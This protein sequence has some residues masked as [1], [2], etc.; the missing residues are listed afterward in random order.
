MFKTAFFGGFFV[1]SGVTAG[2][3][4]STKNVFIFSGAAGAAVDINTVA[5][6]I[7]N[8]NS[9]NATG[10]LIILKEDTSGQVEVWYSAD[11]QN[12]GSKT[13]V[14]TLVGVDITTATFNLA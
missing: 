11:M 8:D 2:S 7:A 12:N 13:L 1:E 3:D 5:T 6:Q 10:G 14:A 4:F 9:V